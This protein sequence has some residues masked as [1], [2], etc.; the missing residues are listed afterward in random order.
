MLL[1]IRLGHLHTSLAAHKIDLY[2]KAQ[3]TQLNSICIILL[4]VYLVRIYGSPMKGDLIFPHQLE[5]SNE[6]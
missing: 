6:N 5:L 3:T 2:S 1:P 4:E